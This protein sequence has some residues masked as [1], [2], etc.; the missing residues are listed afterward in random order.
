MIK[1]FLSQPMLG[2]SNDEIQEERDRIFE[3]L[4]S[5]HDEEIMEVPSFF[6]H[7]YA[8]G[9]NPVYMLSNSIRL[10]SEADLVVFTKDWDDARGCRIEHMVCAEY[11]IPHE[12]LYEGGF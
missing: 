6:P 12:E 2:R 11:G 5:E 9:M 4:Q 3:K 10:L 1:V 7:A 8:K